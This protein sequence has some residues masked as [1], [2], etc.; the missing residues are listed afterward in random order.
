MGGGPRGRARTLARR[1]GDLASR[2]GRLTGA[3]CPTAGVPRAR[4]RVRS[5]SERPLSDEAMIGTNV[6]LRP[7]SGSDAFGDACQDCYAALVEAA[8]GYD[9]ISPFEYFASCGDGV[10]VWRAY[11]HR[12]SAVFVAEVR[13]ASAPVQASASRPFDPLRHIWRDR[14]HHTARAKAQPVQPDRGVPPPRHLTARC[15]RHRLGRLTDPPPLL[16]R[17]VSQSGLLIG[18]LS[19][20]GRSGARG[21]R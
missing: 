11:A 15:Y 18:F 9:S 20:S 14:D 13:I 16:G 7:C 5:R 21:R 10:Q 4:R 12:D 1:S 8:P 3:D 19:M 6:H 2:G 17:G